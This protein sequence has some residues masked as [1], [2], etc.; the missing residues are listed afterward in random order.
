M[1]AVSQAKWNVK[2]LFFKDLIVVDTVGCD[3]ERA[4][5]I[6]AKGKGGCSCTCPSPCG[7]PVQRK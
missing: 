5:T 1:V 3:K 4:S 6:F 2:D 7:C